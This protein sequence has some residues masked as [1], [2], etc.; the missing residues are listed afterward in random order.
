MIRFIAW[1]TISN[2][3]PRK[4]Y[5][6]VELELIY[7]IY[8]IGCCCCCVD[9]E[10]ICRLTAQR[11]FGSDDLFSSARKT[12]SH[13]STLLLVLSYRAYLSLSLSAAFESPWSPYRISVVYD[14]QTL[15]NSKI[16][17]CT[18]RQLVLSHIPIATFILYTYFKYCMASGEKVM[19]KLGI[20]SEKKY[21]FDSKNLLRFR[22]AFCQSFIWFI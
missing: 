15:C 22:C 12:I 17:I 10:L 7:K 19:Y 21:I 6:D 3:K 18:T 4:T 11:M 9:S 1:D 14:S 8:K 5:I 13:S 16:V 20:G 2:L